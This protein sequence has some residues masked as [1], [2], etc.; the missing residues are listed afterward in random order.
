MSA[1]SSLHSI[2]QIRNLHNRKIV[3]KLLI[4]KTIHKNGKTFPPR[5]ASHRHASGEFSPWPRVFHANGVPKP[6]SVG[7]MAGNSA[8][9][10]RRGDK[11]LLTGFNG[12]FLAFTGINQKTASDKRQGRRLRAAGELRDG[13]GRC[14]QFRK[15]RRLPAAGELRGISRQSAPPPVDFRAS[16][17]SIQRRVLLAPSGSGVV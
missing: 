16:G 5:R 15:Q 11:R 9:T 10:G 6:Q 14:F 1:K 3:K 4:F 2:L 8:R 12:R 13:K 17:K 7:G